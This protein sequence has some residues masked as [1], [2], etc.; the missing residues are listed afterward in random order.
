MN[1]VELRRLYYSVLDHILREMSAH[2]NEHNPK[3]ARALVTLDPKTDT[4]SDAKAIQPLLDLT[5]ST[6][7]DTK[8]SVA[9]QHFATVTGGIGGN[10]KMT[11]SRLISEHHG[12]LKAM[13]SVLHALKLSV[14]LGASTAMCENSFSALKN[15][16]VEEN[17]RGQWSIHVKLRLFN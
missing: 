14:T 7:V 1:N 9:K 13:P 2:F 3:L 15:I 5:N 16:F 8:C 12:V 17:R 6:I 11:V 10:D 4:F